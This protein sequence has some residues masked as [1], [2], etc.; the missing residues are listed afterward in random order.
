MKGLTRRGPAGSPSI[1]FLHGG[2]INRHMWSP[3]IDRLYDRFDCLAIDLPGHG[4]RRNEPFTM[5]GSVERSVA[6]LD[7]L[8]IGRAAVVGLSLGGYVAQAMAATY[9]SRVCGLVLSGATIR[10]TG[11]DGLTARLYGYVMPVVARRAARSFATKLTESLGADVAQGMLDGGLSLSAGGQAMRRL[12][13]VDYAA[14]LHGYPGPITIANGE[15]DKGNRKGEAR[16]LDLFPAATVETIEDAGHACALQ[17][18]DAFAKAVAAL[19][20][21]C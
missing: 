20:E 5:A 6:T 19:T 11:W 3:V 21:R 18:P 17:Q 12:P 10:Y 8:S 14:Q 7:A 15:R 4:D 13:G 1:V 9:S 2:V 16:F